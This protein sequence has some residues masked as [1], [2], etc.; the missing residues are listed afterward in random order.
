MDHSR[1]GAVAP[2]NVHRRQDVHS[3]NREWWQRPD[4]GPLCR[5]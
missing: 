5:I 1:E 4:Q 2:V 3:Q